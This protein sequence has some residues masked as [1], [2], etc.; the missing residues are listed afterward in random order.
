MLIVV[1]VVLLV[2]FLLA[3]GVKIAVE[4]QTCPL[5]KH[6]KAFCGPGGCLA[7]DQHGQACGCRA[8]ELILVHRP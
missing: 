1:V 8:S 2:V 4:T 3:V 5:C 6:G 7:G